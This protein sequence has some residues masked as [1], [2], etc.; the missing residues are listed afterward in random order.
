MQPEQVHAMYRVAKG[1]CTCLPGLVA[2][3]V[4][5]CPFT[6]NSQHLRSSKTAFC[7]TPNAALQIPVWTRQMSHMLQHSRVLLIIH[8]SSNVHVVR[9][10]N[11]QGYSMTVNF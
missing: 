2:H 9:R 5:R 4:A 11:M 3:V 8:H 1:L 10:G 6:G 7:E